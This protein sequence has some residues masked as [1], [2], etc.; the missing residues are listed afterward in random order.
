M[1]MLPTDVQSTLI[2]SNLN[3]QLQ[4]G[5]KNSLSTLLNDNVSFESKL[6]ITPAYPDLSNGNKNSE[7]KVRFRPQLV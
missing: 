5:E 7:N 1:N 2:P 4:A 3:P 6:K